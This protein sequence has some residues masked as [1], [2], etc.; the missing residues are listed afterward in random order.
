MCNKPV[1]SSNWNRIISANQ[2]TVGTT[3]TCSCRGAVV[4]DGFDSCRA[5]FNHWREGGHINLQ[6]KTVGGGPRRPGFILG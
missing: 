2:S 3:P 6:Q 1:D 4:R 5:M